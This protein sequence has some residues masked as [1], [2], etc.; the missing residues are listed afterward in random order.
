M[1]FNVV[2]VE[3]LLADTVWFAVR[4]DLELLDVLRIEGEEDAS[5]VAVVSDAVGRGGCDSCSSGAGRGL[6][7]FA[8]TA[9]AKSGV[10]MAV[11]VVIAGL[12]SSRLVGE[13][14]AMTERKSS[15]LPRVSIDCRRV[16]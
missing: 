9:A 2:T 5:G 7:L 4:A 8:E 10:D 13:E 15:K 3:P 12:S 6:S 16:C 1:S 11:D 14:K